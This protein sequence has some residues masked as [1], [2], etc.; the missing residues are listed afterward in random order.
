MILGVFVRDV[1]SGNAEREPIDDP[2]GWRVIGAAGTRPSENP[3]IPIEGDNTANN[4]STDGTTSVHSSSNPNPQTGMNFMSNAH[5]E[6]L[7][8]GEEEGNDTFS[9]QTPRPNRYVFQKEEGTLL[10]DEKLSAEP[11][12]L[13]M[14]SGGI[15]KVSMTTTFASKSNTRSQSYPLENPHRLYQ[16]MEKPPL[17]PQNKY[18]TQPPKPIQSPRIT[19]NL[20]PKSRPSLSS[21]SL[22]YRVY[23]QQDSSSASPSDSPTTTSSFNN[24]INYGGANGGKMT[25]VEKKRYELQMRVNRARTQMPSHI[26]LRVFR[27]PSE[28]VEIEEMLAGL[29]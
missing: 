29:V 21:Q 14:D 28:C 23:R 19:T 3:L 2:T 6:L 18:V 5:L 25:E 9:E 4:T 16:Q 1:D 13:T 8:E 10:V 22:P 24:A 17:L 26:V 7:E 20:I 11:E 15:P 27:E 12:S